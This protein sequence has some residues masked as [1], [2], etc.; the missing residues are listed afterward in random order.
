M[1][2]SKK[3]QLERKSRLR[4]ENE[5]YMRA[6]ATLME[7]VVN[8]RR[9]PKRMMSENTAH[10]AEYYAASLE[11]N[12]RMRMYLEAEQERKDRHELLRFAQSISAWQQ[13][14]AS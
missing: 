2:Q 11:E 12:R 5:K 8:D 10:L 6:Y 4:E 3:D 7:S 13:R 1:T 14:F 9:V